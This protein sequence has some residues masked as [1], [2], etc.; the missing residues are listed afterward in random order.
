[1]AVTIVE[2]IDLK[3]SSITGRPCNRTGGSAKPKINPAKLGAIYG[4]IQ[5]LYL[6]FSTY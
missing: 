5:N 1:M 4:K 2:L 6:K 3:A